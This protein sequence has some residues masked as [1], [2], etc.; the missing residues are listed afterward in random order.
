MITGHSKGIDWTSHPLRALLFAPANDSRKMARFSSSPADAV[1]VDL[2]DA[3]ALAQKTAARGMAAATLPACRDQVAMVRVNGPIS[4][5][6]E[7]DIRAVVSSSLDCL[8]IPKVESA[9]V[10]LAADEI[11][12]RLEHDDHLPER[13]I[14]FLPLIE[15]AV[16]VARCEEIA[17]R[18]PARVV[19][20]IFG[21][22]DFSADMGIDLTVG[23]EELLYARSRIAVATRA[24]RM[25]SPLDGPYLDFRNLDGLV[26]DTERSRSLGFRGRVVIHPSQVEPV[27]SAYSQLSNAELERAQ[28]IV[29]AF[30]EAESRGVAAIEVD[31][32]LVDYPVYRSALNRL[33]M[34]K[35]LKVG[36]SNV[37]TS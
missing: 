6:M 3:V 17:T 30:E 12:T 22:G 4:G 7:D 28:R 37:R 16:G 34:F 5:L 9:D 21:L 27:Q 33:E 19:T 24:A 26:R 25:R 15:T 18:S 2:E 10:L 36:R 32:G 31:G 14:R 29:A 23:G 20:L 35:G 11:V 1:V 8:V 13:R